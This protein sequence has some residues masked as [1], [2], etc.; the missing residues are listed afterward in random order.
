MYF[1]AQGWLQLSKHVFSSFIINF[2]C[3]SAAFAICEK[4]ISR[5]ERQHGIPEK[6]L[7]AIAIVE[8]GR[9]FGGEK[10]AWPWTINANGV[11]YIF[12]TKEEAVTKVKELQK[13]G[14]RSIDVGCM[15]VNLMYHP[16]AFESIE[17][18][19]DPEKN[20]AYAASF[21]KQKMTTR[22]NWHHAVADYHSA[23]E[24]LGD[25]YKEM[26]LQTHK[27][28]QGQSTVPDVLSMTAKAQ[29]DVVRV[30]MV[31]VGQ[32]QAPVNIRF[33]SFL[34]RGQQAQKRAREGRGNGASFYSIA[35]SKGGTHRT[36][37]TTRTRKIPMEVFA[38][39]ENRTSLHKSARFP[40]HR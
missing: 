19:F 18:A 28:I 1:L 15:Q 20:I 37:I 23:T 3:L 24:S 10:V 4:F 12:D 35:A 5:F 32:R 29:P 2:V 9:S 34:N 39:R 31:G 36:N 13:S 17:A 11:P 27:K 40:G 6:L 25:P 38:A 16:D 33:G 7:S 26:V 22:G 30:P 21:L 8:S 14:V